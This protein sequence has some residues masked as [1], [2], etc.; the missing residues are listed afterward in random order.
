MGHEDEAVD[1]HD[2]VDQA[3]KLL[4]AA[5]WCIRDTAFVTEAGALVWLVSGRNGENV[6]RA[7]EPT[8]AAAWR[9]ACDQA[10][11][12]GMLPGW[13]VSQPKAG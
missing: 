3:M 1:N 8:Q 6:I 7:E 10:R 13:R 4:H 9:A 2:D 5:G 11:A 12:V